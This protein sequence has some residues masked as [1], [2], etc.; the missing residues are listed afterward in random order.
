[1]AETRTELQRARLI[2]KAVSPWL[3]SVGPVPE[4]L[5]KLFLDWIENGKVASSAEIK[6]GLREARKRAA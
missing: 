4:S 3:Y 6:A 5:N 1:M 2:A